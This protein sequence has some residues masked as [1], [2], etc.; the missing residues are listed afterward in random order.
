VTTLGGL[1]LRLFLLAL[2]ARAVADLVSAAS[3]GFSF[4]VD[5]GMAALLGVLACGL[6]G[7]LRGRPES[8]YLLAGILVC[9]FGACVQIGRLA[10]HRL[11]NHNDLFHVVLMVGAGLLFQAARRFGR[12]A[13]PPVA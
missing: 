2:A 9:L 3:G 11:F 12:E 5:D 10:P 1:A 7:L 8:R 13:T 4:A 6:Y